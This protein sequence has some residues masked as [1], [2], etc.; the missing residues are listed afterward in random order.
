[1]R[2]RRV[3]VFLVFITMLIGLLY[4]FKKSNEQRDVVYERSSLLREYTRDRNVVAADIAKHDYKAAARYIE[5]TA[6]KR[7]KANALG[8]FLGQSIYKNE[9]IVGISKC[10]TDS[11][12][13]A[14]FGCMHGFL[15]SALSQKK[16][17][18]SAIY[19]ACERAKPHGYKGDCA[20]ALGHALAATNGYTDSAINSSL[21]ACENFPSIQNEQDR[22]LD[23]NHCKAGV[24]MEYYLARMGAH[25]DGIYGTIS[26]DT[27]LQFDKNNPYGLC[28]SV[29]DRN[30]C[31]GQITTWWLN[32]VHLTKAEVVSLCLG[33]STQSGKAYCVG[34]L[35]NVVYGG[36]EKYLDDIVRSNYNDVGECQ[37]IDIYWDR[38]ACY[39]TRMIRP[40]YESLLV[41][42]KKDCAELELGDLTS[43]CEDR[44]QERMETYDK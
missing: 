21:K 33:I 34:G 30:I 18:Y 6:G 41:R 8:S 16:N 39:Q 42:I 24:M 7:R 2:I 26:K 29:P 13:E 11:T 36:F 37:K 12:Y 44:Y 35:S 4:G 20:H 25:G 14:F 15:S 3:H 17:S 5:I 43:V 40:M 28:N 31:Y 38:L 22:S 27:D 32:D 9:G 10:F 1:M 19:Q 23:F